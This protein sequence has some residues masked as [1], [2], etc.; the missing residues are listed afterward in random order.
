M[1]NLFCYDFVNQTIVASK[2]TLRKAGIPGT[3]EHKE[4]T[5]MLKKNPTFTVAEKEIKKATGKNSY[6]GL[7]KALMEDYISI[8]DR[9][10]ELREQY[11]RALEKGR[12]PLARKWFLSTFENFHV[13]TAKEEIEI[14]RVAAITAARADTESKIVTMPA[15]VNQ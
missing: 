14:A 1:K 3:P 10:D 7:N 8:Q 9:A 13:A 2:T 12:F 4:L 11:D 15:A 5:K 6:S